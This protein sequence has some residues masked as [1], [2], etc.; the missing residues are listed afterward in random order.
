MP[1]RDDSWFHQWTTEE[2]ALE[3]HYLI[4]NWF[5]LPQL[6]WV[7]FDTYNTVTGIYCLNLCGNI[8]DIFTADE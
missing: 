8:E 6:N 3:I 7:L 2:I 4:I 1:H 5:C